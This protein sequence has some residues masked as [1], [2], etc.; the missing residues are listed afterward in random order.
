MR[1]TL[2]IGVISILGAAWLIRSAIAVGFAIFAGPIV[3]AELV[4][5]AAL[6][7]LWRGLGGAE[8]AVETVEAARPA[9]DRRATAVAKS[10]RLARPA[11]PAGLSGRSLVG[12]T[13]G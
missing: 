9:D 4:L 6:Y 8:R 12:R 2:T 10:P 13:G 5:L 1:L 11:A 3:L 7:A